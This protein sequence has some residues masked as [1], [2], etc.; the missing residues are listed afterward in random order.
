MPDVARGFSLPGLRKKLAPSGG[1]QQQH[2]LSLSGVIATIDRKLSAQGA[3]AA[4][5]PAGSQH[6]GLPAIWA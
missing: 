1:A 4:A 3:S 5:P 2:A 6:A